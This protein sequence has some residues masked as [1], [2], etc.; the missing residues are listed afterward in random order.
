MG[1]VSFCLFSD[2]GI[3]VVFDGLVSFKDKTAVY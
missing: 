2:A 3:Y 1:T